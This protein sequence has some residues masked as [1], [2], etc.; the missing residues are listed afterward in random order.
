MNFVPLLLHIIFL[1]NCLC[2]YFRTSLRLHRKKTVAESMNNCNV[3]ALLLQP[4]FPQAPGAP[5]NPLCC[6]DL[7]V[8]CQ[9]PWGS[10][11]RRIDRLR[12]FAPRDCLSG[13][14]ESQ[15][16]FHIL[17]FVEVR[18]L[19]IV[20]SS[21]RISFHVEHTLVHN[22]H[23]EIEYILICLSS[24]VRWFFSPHP[25]NAATTSRPAALLPRN[26]LSPT[27]HIFY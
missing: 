1:L 23:E 20:S 9:N 2:P 5:F 14:Q 13:F 22:F 19:T 11:Q 24:A 18:V 12:L 6:S 7:G 8:L 26:H 15:P 17:T 10:A 4:I 3:T 27:I 16:M 25:T 21:S